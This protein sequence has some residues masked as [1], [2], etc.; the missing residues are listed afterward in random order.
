VLINHKLTLTLAGLLS[1]AV[2]L[3][4]P[5][6]AQF[7]EGYKFL[8]AV[9][10]RDDKAVT[11]LLEKGGPSLIN[12]RDQTSLET[13]LHIAARQK[14]LT[15]VKFLIGQGANVDMRNSN[16]ETPLVIAC[17]VGFIE[18]VQY[19]LAAGARVDES[20]S[21]GETPLITAVH[22]RNVGLMRLLLQAGAD[23]DRADNSGRTARDYAAQ[24][25]KREV[26]LGEIKASAKPKG[27]TDQTKPIFG[28][29]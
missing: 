2:A 11:E 28:P 1:A 22:N 26:L 27:K 12:T 17:N 9:T 29:K 20:G 16:G 23:P 7:S 6:Q 21:T 24:D 14:N 19:L 8:Q 10:K 25:N 5:A 18:G 13:A 15:Y 4:G 3:P